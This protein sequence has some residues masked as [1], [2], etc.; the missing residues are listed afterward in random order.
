MEEG[1]VAK[2]DPETQKQIE[3]GVQKALK[4]LPLD[5]LKS[6]CRLEVDVKD[7]GKSLAEARAM[8][9]KTATTAGN[10]SAELDKELLAI[11]KEIGEL[12]KSHL[13]D[14]KQLE[15]KVMLHYKEFD[16]RISD[17]DQE[18]G[19]DIRYC[20]NNIKKLSQQLEKVSNKLD[21]LDKYVD[22]EIYKTLV[23]AVKDIKVMDK[24]LAA[25]ERKA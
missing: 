15:S 10:L 2:I 20:W 18:A 22:G 9:A 1:G 6:I 23:Q 7:M 14:G 13:S 24:R 5:N 4:S 3:A 21:I 17:F 12:K 11:F 19:E 16:A 8:L 25:L